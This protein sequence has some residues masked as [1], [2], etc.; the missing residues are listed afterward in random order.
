MTFS[1]GQKVEKRG[2]D[3]HFVGIIVAK[4][5]KRN[6][7]TV[8]YVVE[9]DDGILHITSERQLKEYYK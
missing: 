8:R 4:F 7:K 1:V 5:L 2:E 3:S 9:N 6:Q